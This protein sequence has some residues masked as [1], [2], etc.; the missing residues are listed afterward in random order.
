MLDNETYQREMVRMFDSFRETHKWEKS[1]EGVDCRDCPLQVQKTKAG[2]DNPFNV[3]KIYNAVEKW[4]KEHQPQ[5][6]K[7]S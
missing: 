2:C 7:V 5:K 6:Y 1:C 3:V 4:S